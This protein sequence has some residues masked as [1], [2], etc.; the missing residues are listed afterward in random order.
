MI[1]ILEIAASNCVVSA[2]LITVLALLH[3]RRTNPRLMHLLLVAAL[4]KLLMPP[5]FTIEFTSSNIAAFEALPVQAANAGDLVDSYSC[6]SKWATVPRWLIVLVASWALGSFGV[7]SVFV[8]RCLYF[9]RQLK[10]ARETPGFIDEMTRSLSHR[11]GLN[12]VPETIVLPLSFSPAVWSF[13]GRAKVVLPSYLVEKMPRERLQTIIAHELA[14][15]RRKDFWVRHLELAVV[16][17][18]WWNP[19]VWLALRKIHELEEQCCDAIVLREL[20]GAAR[21]YAFALVETMEFLGNKT[22]WLPLGASAASSA[23]SLSW[24]IEM[25]KSGREVRGF[26]SRAA[27][28]CGCLLT[29]PMMLAFSQVGLQSTESGIGIESTDGAFVFESIDG[30]M[31]IEAAD[32][33]SGME[34]SNGVMGFQSSDGMGA[35]VR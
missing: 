12:R 7:L 34:L 1:G 8:V 15:I 17:V 27:I 5:F 6:A 4:A 13:A 22:L 24:R 28:I 20:Q 26:S 25:M 9:M 14:H 32:G 3:R 23:T 30:G 2:L 11:M 16:I 31:E 29:A 19:F 33:A 21:N 35:E 18:Y 10:T